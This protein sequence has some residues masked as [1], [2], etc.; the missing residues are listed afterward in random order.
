[1][2]LRTMR[3]GPRGCRRLLS[4]RR[5]LLFDLPPSLALFYFLN[6]CVQ[7]FALTANQGW[8]LEELAMPQPTVN[9]YYAV[10]FM[11]WSLKPLYALLADRFPLC[12]YHFRPWLAISSAGSACC[13]ILAGTY[14]ETIGGAFLVT[15]VR[16]ICNACAEFMLGAVLV[17]EAREARGG[18][19]TTLQ[20]AAN[21]CRYAGTFF[22]AAVGLLLYPC[23][24][25]HRRLPDRLIIALTAG[26][27]AAVALLVPWL[28]ELRDTRGRRGG[29]GD[30]DGGS[31]GSGGGGGGGR[32]A[33]ALLVLLPLQAAVLWAEVCTNSTCLAQGQH[34]PQPRVGSPSPR[35]RLRL[36]P[37]SRPS[38]GPTNQACSD[39]SCALVSPHVWRQTLCAHTTRRSLLQP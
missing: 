33:V 37:V 28:P 11:P 10:T 34:A 5:L 4:F 19:A 7:S 15:L 35:P 6:S 9:L 8:L 32:A 30:G 27:P 17:N 16:S 13:Y 31:D 20:A 26:F 1:M 25:V 36:R 21:S 3:D 18:S 12:G 14:V 29:D 2:P 24:T 38:A 22:S 39:S 23:G